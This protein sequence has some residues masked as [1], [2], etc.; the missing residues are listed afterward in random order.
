MDNNTIQKRFGNAIRL[1]REEK[2]MS[3]EKLAEMADLHRTY[4]SDVERGARNVSLIN[5]WR[6]SEGLEIS[7]SELF[8]RIEQ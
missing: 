2:R 1:I 3:Q 5:I 4:I 6:I 8:K 7:L